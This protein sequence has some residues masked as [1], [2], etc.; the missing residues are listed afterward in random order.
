MDTKLVEFKL[1][2]AD[3]VIGGILAV[4]AVAAFA[5]IGVWAVPFLIVAATNT[6]YL[7]VMV[8]ALLLFA[9]VVLDK[10]TWLT[11]LYKWK[12]ISRSIRKAVIRED[13]VG[14]LTTAIER[15][16]QKLEDIAVSM[17][18]AATARKQH[19][20]EITE[21]EK[22]AAASD[23]LAAAAHKQGASENLVTRH[24]IAADRW[25]KTADEMRPMSATLAEYQTKL[26][27]AHDLVVNNQ[28]DLKNQR[29]VLEVR[30]SAMKRA[31]GTASAFK[32][33]FGSNPDLGIHAEAV[34]E[35]ELQILENEAEIDQ[36]L[37]AINPKLQDEQLRDSAEKEQA[38]RR[39]NKFLEEAKPVPQL[40]ASTVKEPV[41]R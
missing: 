41:G 21:V 29:D 3:K 4:L 35:V 34:E 5:V 20:A 10:N 31:A 23:G 38:M 15:L 26:E 18:E 25:R 36:F 11:V 13:P 27:Q 8:V 40:V 12:N 7:G 16:D 2:P 17:R 24:A 22:K 39:F 6:L 33:F 19:D 1:K 30:L 28:A 37:R 9:M 14:V 32:R